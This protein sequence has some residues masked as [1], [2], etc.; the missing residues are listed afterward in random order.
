MSVLNDEQYQKEKDELNNVFLEKFKEKFSRYADEIA[1]VSYAYGW[2]DGAEGIVQ[3]KHG[4]EGYISISDLRV[5]ICKSK[6]VKKARAKF[7]ESFADYVARLKIIE[8]T[9][10]L[11]D[12]W[13][14][15]YSVGLID[16]EDKE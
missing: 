15:G 8:Y 13:D 9:G 16:K 12:G 5:N 6:E 11:N 10:G 1:L 7:I 3:G 4:D 2:N 14:I